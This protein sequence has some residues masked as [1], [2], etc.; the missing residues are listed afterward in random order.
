MWNI[1]KKK[2]KYYALKVNYEILKIYGQKKIIRVFSLNWIKKKKPD[3]PLAN[4]RKKHFYIFSLKNKKLSDF[5]YLYFW[6]SLKSQRI[7][8][9]L[10]LYQ[11]RTNTCRILHVSVISVSLFLKE[12][13][14]SFLSY[15][16]VRYLNK[17]YENCQK[18]TDRI[19]NKIFYFFNNVFKNKFILFKNVFKKKFF[20]I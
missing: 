6:H 4:K 15:W 9:T 20:F 16:I 12:Y 14:N 3:S 10:N 1:Y 19:K 7:L 8:S 5:I 17:K 13:K 18:I 2:E 11:S